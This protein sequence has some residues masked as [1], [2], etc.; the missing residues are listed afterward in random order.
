MRNGSMTHNIQIIDPLFGDSLIPECKIHQQL[1]TMKTENLSHML[2][3]KMLEESRKD[4]AEKN[5]EMI[6]SP[7]KY[8]VNVLNFLTTKFDNIFT[9]F[10]SNFYQSDNQHNLDVLISLFI[11]NQTIREKNLSI[12]INL[13]YQQL[14]SQYSGIKSNYYSYSNLRSKSNPIIVD[15]YHKYVS[16]HLKEDYHISNPSILKILDNP[17]YNKLYQQNK[18]AVFSNNLEEFLKNILVFKLENE[19]KKDMSNSPV[20]KNQPIKKF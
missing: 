10:D 2:I 1:M 6:K 4:K 16:H 7:A 17:F 13:L 3:I 20:G 8:H 18:E 14:I 12:S 9:W 19:M 15:E 5:F 11:Q